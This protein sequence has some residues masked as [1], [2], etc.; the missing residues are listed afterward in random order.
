IERQLGASG[1]ITIVPGERDALLTQAV[2][3]LVEYFAGTRER[4]DVLLD[5]LGTPFQSRV[6]ELVQ[7]IP[8]GQT[9]SYAELA[10]DLGRPRAT[11]AVGAAVG[12]N[13]LPILIPCHRVV[14]IH[15]ELVGYVG[16]LACKAWL[17]AHERATRPV[18]T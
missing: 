15:G 10:R 5:L 1:K 14:G 2:Q 6:W 16:G 7:A 11:R 12:A 17:L 18:T 3:E 9:R 4:F 13:P 8:Y